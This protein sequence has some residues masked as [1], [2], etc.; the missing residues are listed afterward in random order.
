MP[1]YGLPEKIKFCGRCLASNAQPLACNEFKHTPEMKHDY[2]KFDAD[3]ICAACRFFES[4]KNGVIDWQAREKELLELLAQ[5][6]S[7]DG[8][9]DCLVP[10]SGGKDSAYA[11]HVLKYK[12]GMHP[13]T[14][15]WTPHLY[16]DIGWKNFQN[17]IHVGGFDNYLFSPNGK[18]HRLLARNAFLNLLHPFQPFILGQKTFAPKVAARFGIKL[19]FYGENQGEYGDKVSVSQKKFVMGGSKDEKGYRLDYAK[20][21]DPPET[22]FLGGKSLADYFNEGLTYGDL[23]PFLPADPEILRQHNIEFHYLGYYLKWV[24]QECYYYAVKHTGFEANPVR[25]EGT[26][27][28]YNSIDDKTDGFFYYTTFIKFGF[29]RARYDASQEI[30]NEH[31]TKEEGSTLIKR[32][33][34]EFPKRYFPEFLD[35]IGLS[36]K[37]FTDTI[38]SFRAPH[39][40]EKEK[41]AWKLKYQE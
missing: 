4:R 2:I 29:G 5:Y 35:Y 27:S 41:G 13:L 26:Y 21:T 39:L 24:P 22:V 17:W 3:G 11:S 6:R 31:I 36:E 28:K 33:D 37:E 15:T 40:W 1:P 19:I 9:F 18:I 14:V 30:R 10:G 20:P 12:Y 38:D 8:S 32:F 34:G 7:T 25:T 23:A 16:T